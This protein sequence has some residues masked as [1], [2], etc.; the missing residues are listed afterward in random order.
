M[1]LCKSSLI[2]KLLLLAV[3]IYAIAMVM[4]LQPEIDQLQQQRDELAAQVTDAQQKN[5]E[6]AEDI[7]RIGTDEAI[8]EI[9][10]ERLNLVEDGEIVFIDS[11][12]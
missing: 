9:A 2:T 1:R 10:R 8:I 5:L 12:K 11:G 6:L 7:E 3:M 4:T